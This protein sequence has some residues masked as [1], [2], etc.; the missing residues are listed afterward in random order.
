MVTSVDFHSSRCVRGNA[1]NVKVKSSRFVIGML[2]C[3]VRFE[4]RID[5]EIFVGIKMLRDMLCGTIHTKS[6]LLD[7]KIVF[8]R[9]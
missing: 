5:I 3:T 2:K 6:T 8:Y 4:L 1:A 9:L 7:I